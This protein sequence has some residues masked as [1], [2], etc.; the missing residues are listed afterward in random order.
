MQKATPI[1]VAFLFLY[2]VI[3]KLLENS[4]LNKL[5]NY[6]TDNHLLSHE[7]K[8][9]LPSKRAA[10]FLKNE[11]LGIIN[12]SVFLPQFV[13]IEDFSQ[14]LTDLKLLDAV[15]LQFELFEVYN[16]IPQIEKKDTFEKFIEWAPIVLQDFNEIDSYLANAT[17]L[18]SNLSTLKRLDNWFPNQEPTSLSLNYIKFFE[19]LNLLYHKFYATLIRKHFAYQ[20]LIYREA[21]KNLTS[22]INNFNG[23]LIFAGFNALNK[24]EEVIIQELLANEKAEIFWDID[25]SFL[26]SKHPA[27]KFINRYKTTWP[28]YQKNQF[29]WIFSHFTDKKNITLIGA[30]KQVAQLKTA[31]QIIDKIAKTDSDLSN[32]AFVL[33]EEQLLNVALESLPES[34]DKVNITMGFALQNTPL[35]SLFMSLFQANINAFK[36][37]KRTTLY[38]KDFD[39]ILSHPYI[40]KISVNNKS[41]LLGFIKKR[42]LDFIDYQKLISDKIVTPQKIDFIFENIGNDISKFIKNCIELINILKEEPSFSK[43]E[44]E[45]LYRFYNLFLELESLENNYHFITNL[46]TLFHFYQN[47]IRHEKLYFKGEPLDGLQIMGL[48]ETRVLDFENLIITSVNEGVLPKA[49]ASQSVLPFEIKKAYQLPTYEERDHIYAYHFFRLLQRSKNIYLIY[50]TEVDDFGASEKSRFITQLELLKPDEINNQ[51][52]ITNIES[53]LLK[54][55]EITANK[56]VKD[57]FKTLAEDGL[58]PSAID[59]F[60]RNPID[61]YYSKILKLKDIDTLD[62]TIALNTFGTVIHDSLFDLYKHFEGKTL[63]KKELE[64]SIKNIDHFLIENAKKSYQN[65]NIST[66]KNKLYFEMAKQYIHKLINHEIKLIESGHTIEVIALETPLKTSIQVEGIDFSINLKGI[67]DRIDKF[68][69]QI[70]IV[71]Y[72]TGTVLLNNLKIT[73]FKLLSQNDRFSKALQLLIYAYMYSKSSIASMP[74]EAGIISF[75]KLNKYIFKLNFNK[76]ASNPN[77][78]ITQ[79]KIDEFEP[80]L[81]DLLKSIFNTESFLEKIKTNDHY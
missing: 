27:A 60:L 39:S 35:A 62:E 19:T 2:H 67:A 58:S 44:N 74:F 23:K 7:T 20:G 64:N 38:Y 15:H 33:G 31:S 17:S 72:K 65:G 69:G 34:V 8:I 52:T 70:R 43:L 73:D 57:R 49:K 56:T 9:V 11:L 25:Q 66:G 55:I 41:H 77:Y 76:D 63:S 50:N 28:Y 42:N 40:S 14:E 47:L 13:S 53:D 81:K 71:D 61:F 12:Q 59:L 46:D 78:L 24:A 30:S 54:P 48:L 79:E 68:N 18:F 5:A 37:G 32:T 80:V 45:Y 4:F 26:K 21:V 3:L 51:I 16:S 1:G 6:L 36:Y 22:Y 29:N 75:K 10:L